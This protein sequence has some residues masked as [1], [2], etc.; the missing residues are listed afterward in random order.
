M[1][2]CDGACKHSIINL[3]CGKMSLLFVSWACCVSFLNV[4]SLTAQ[5]M[6]AH[7]YSTTS[8]N[9]AHAVVEA[10]ELGDPLSCRPLGLHSCTVFGRA[11]TAAAGTFYLHPAFSRCMSVLTCNA[12]YQLPITKWPHQSEAPGGAAPPTRSQLRLMQYFGLPATRQGP[13]GQRQA[14]SLTVSQALDRVLVY[15]WS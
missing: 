6:L 11:W 9:S 10:P 4:S 15:T 12:N 1:K 3:L 13:A 2:S 5:W 8:S 7:V 14:P